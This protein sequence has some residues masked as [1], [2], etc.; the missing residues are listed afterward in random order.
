MRPVHFRSGGVLIV[1][2]TPIRM[3]WA[4]QRRAGRIGVSAFS[5]GACLGFPKVIGEMRHDSGATTAPM[6]DH[7]NNRRHRSGLFPGRRRSRFYDKF[8]RFPGSQ[9]SWRNNGIIA[10]LF[11]DCRQTGLQRRRPKAVSETNGPRRFLRNLPK[12]VP[13][14][15]K[16]VAGTYKKLSMVTPG[17]SGRHQ[18]DT[19]SRERTKHVRVPVAART[20]DKAVVGCRRRGSCTAGRL[21]G[22]HADRH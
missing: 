7:R 16:N 19:V 6:R 5:G 17:E 14:L 13:K 18:H 21:P 8:F 4:R 9:Q 22:R 15:V 1:L 20:R 11:K 2:D 12:T 3:P 10:I